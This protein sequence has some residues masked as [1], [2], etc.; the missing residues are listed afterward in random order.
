MGLLSTEA[1]VGVCNSSQK[2]YES[3][4]YCIPKIYKNYQLLTPRGT[5]IK[6]KV[7]D[8]KR[9]STALVDVECD[10]CKRVKEMKYATYMRIRKDDGTTYCHAGYSKLFNSGENSSLWNPNLSEEERIRGRNYPEYHEFIQRVLKRDHYTCQC[11]NS[12]SNGNVVVHHL[13]GYNWCKEKRT[14]DT[15]GITLCEDCHINFHSIYGQGDN[16]KEQFEE[17][18]GRKII[19]DKYNGEKIRRRMV[20]CFEDDC[21]Y[22]DIEE[23]SEK[24]STCLGSISKTCRGETNS[25]GGKH[26]IWYDKYLELSDEEKIKWANKEV[27][28]PIPKGVVCITLGKI[29][30]SLHSAENE[31]IKFSARRLGI[32]RCCEGKAPRAGKLPDGTPLIW[33]YYEDFLKLPQE[34][35][36]EILARNKDSSNGESFNM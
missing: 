5:K 33:M 9:G 12:K 32:N 11:C 17:W 25:A 3:L 15:N 14:D 19:L 35:Q 23:A 29:F 2:Y 36:N 31:M 10:C 1:E 34:E 20:Y 13:D 16:T 6:V 27:G 22:K 30:T 28:T 24:Q 21:I 26:Y 7:C 18:V 8:L 4:G